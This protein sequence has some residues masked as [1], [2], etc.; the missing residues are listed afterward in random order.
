MT[1]QGTPAFSG[2]ESDRT[3]FREP[4]GD[5]LK[6]LG[7][8]RDAGRLDPVPFEAIVAARSSLA[9]R[10]LDAELAELA[11][12]SLLDDNVLAGI[13]SADAPP[14][15][16]SFECAALSVEIETASTGSG[17]C[18][19]GQLMPPQA[20]ALDVQHAAGTISATADELGRFTIEDVPTGPVR[21][22]VRPADG[23]GA[24]TTDWIVL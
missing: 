22:R 9:W 2:R 13:R 18:L 14:R 21:V 6:L 16:V 19:V 3:V 7:E 4:M 15:L 10:T 20:A 8:L 17:R 5:D 12:D 1:D 11:Y 23:K 24:V